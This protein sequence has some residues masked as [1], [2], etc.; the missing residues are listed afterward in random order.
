METVSNVVENVDH[1]VGSVVTDVVTPIT[2]QVEHT[3]S[4]AVTPV[5]NILHGFAKLRYPAERLLP[6]MSS[7]LAGANGRSSRGRSSCPRRWRRSK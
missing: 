7:T 4:S 2:S 5:A 6:V 1:S 3:V